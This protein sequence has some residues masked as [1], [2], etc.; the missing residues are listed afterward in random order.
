MPAR[1]GRHDVVHDARQQAAARAEQHHRPGTG[2]RPAP[3]RDSRHPRLP[4]LRSRRADQRPPRQAP[5]GQPVTTWLLPIA[6]TLAAAG[7]TYW[8]CIRPMR[9]GRHGKAS[10]G[11]GCCPPPAAIDLDDQIRQAREE[12]MTLR[13][14]ATHP[15]E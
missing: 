11:H 8:C 6:A 10:A 3:Q 5:P 1:H 14:A 9:Q 12:L 15:P 4:D 13:T 7:L 2:T